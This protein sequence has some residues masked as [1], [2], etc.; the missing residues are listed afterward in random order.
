MRY[1]SFSLV[2]EDNSSFPEEFV[3]DTTYSFSLNVT[4][5]GAF[6]QQRLMNPLQGTWYASAYIKK[7]QSESVSKVS[8]L[9]SHLSSRTI[10]MHYHGINGTLFLPA[11]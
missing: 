1:A 5:N 8:L 10:K 7:T 9:Y 6:V 2:Q 3:L 4:P 11:N